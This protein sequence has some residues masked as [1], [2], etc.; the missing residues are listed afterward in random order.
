MS[1]K[2]AGNVIDRFEKAG[3]EIVGAKMIRLTSEV[4]RSHYSHVA[5]KPFYPE[6]EAF[7]S[8]R[9]ANMGASGGI[10]IRRRG[11]EPTHDSHTPSAHG[12]RTPGA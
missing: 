4:L 5:D 10:H 7:M 11:K 6:I 12:E 1:N 2:H 8:S 3:F 9:H